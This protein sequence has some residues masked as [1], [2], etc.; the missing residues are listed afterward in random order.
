VTQQDP[1]PELPLG[2]EQEGPRRRFDADEIHLVDIGVDRAA[3]EQLLSQPRDRSDPEVAR[4]AWPRVFSSVVEQT[5]QIDRAAELDRH[6]LLVCVEHPELDFESLAVQVVRRQLASLAPRH[7]LPSSGEQ[8]TRLRFGY[9]VATV[10]G[11]KVPSSATIG[12]GYI[13][14]AASDFTRRG[15]IGVRTNRPFVPSPGAMPLWR[16]V[17]RDREDRPVRDLDWLDD[18]RLTDPCLRLEWF[19]DPVAELA[20][21]VNGN[22]LIPNPASHGARHSIAFNRSSPRAAERVVHIASRIPG[23]LRLGGGR[24][25]K[26]SL[27]EMV[28]RETTMC[29]DPR[30]DYP[31]ELEAL[32]D[33]IGSGSPPLLYAGFTCGRTP[34]LE[35]AQSR[36]ICGAS[37]LSRTRAS[38]ELLAPAQLANLLYG[39]YASEAR[40][41]EL[42]VS[43]RHLADEL[44]ERTRR[45]LA[46]TP[47]PGLP[48]RGQL[49][50][51]QQHG[52]PIRVDEVPVSV[53]MDVVRHHEEEG[54]R[55]AVHPEVADVVRMLTTP[56]R[57]SGRTPNG[58]ELYGFQRRLVAQIEATFYGAVLASGTGTGKSP[59]AVEAVNRWAGTTPAFRALVIVEDELVAQWLDDVLVGVAGEPGFLT[60]DAKVT[61]IDRDE[62]PARTMARL[63]RDA[64]NGP[65]VVLCGR[66]AA[67]VGARALSR[68]ARRDRTGATICFWD[69][70]LVDEGDFLAGH[71]ATTR[72]VRSIRDNA[73]RAIVITAT[74]IR[75]GA[76]DLVDLV[77]AARAH[78]SEVA[79]R[80]RRRIRAM[81]LT[82]EDTSRVHDA[83]SVVVAR[84]T[85]EEVEA[86]MPRLGEVVVQ[87]VP[88][89]PLERRVVE[90]VEAGLV[91]AY[92][93]LV[94]AAQNAGQLDDKT[95]AGREN[96]IALELARR[97]L[98][99]LGPL[100]IRLACD[101]EAALESRSEAAQLLA[102]DDDLRALRASG[103]RPTMRKLNAALIAKSVAAGQP[104]L[105]FC[106]YV[107]PLRLLRDE[108]REVHGVDAGLL[109]GET[110][111]AERHAS[112]RAFRNGSGVDALLVGPQSLRGKNLQRA[113][114]V[115]H[116]D[117]PR[118]SYRW[119]QR[120]GR[121]ARIG[122]IW[123]EIDVIVPQMENS[124][125][126]YL[127]ELIVTR[128]AEAAA[129]IDGDGARSHLASQFAGL[130]ADLQLGETAT[131]IGYVA[132]RLLEQRA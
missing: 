25:N 99:Q 8:W 28:L 131:A 56:V 97:S 5:R 70:L 75:T 103:Q 104:I 1:A 61:V 80:A 102:I 20:Y 112:C 23:A 71:S 128:A 62:S 108:L 111:A 15:E 26:T 121:A 44:I 19:L 13:V 29:G 91:D 94:E 82:S 116:L 90:K 114:R 126:R 49:Q 16:G 34:S 9:R 93:K 6:A 122:S 92:K 4:R 14:V 69:A 88:V 98:N 40:V 113:R 55:P 101:W 100:A 12:D 117:L 118:A 51:G 39:L 22:S 87:Q 66:T 127:Q 35:L 68:L 30:K 31:A 132:A 2:P 74:P 52:N 27:A 125:M 107:A 120:N 67:R 41:L 18:D 81:R 38:T 84:P 46:V 129:V 77:A 119:E 33:A 32:S 96:R 11:D 48:G 95:E 24:P 89:T 21:L 79:R 85:P 42:D 73:D 47:V 50:V 105:A 106:E 63:D 110:P 60:P 123:P 43:Q 45:T 7:G 59:M 124:F 58:E 10:N 64:G 109:T 65:A 76:S 3:A 130:A 115:L 83:Y 54:R 53:A 72:A 86:V 36:A 78:S 17:L 37:V 57:D